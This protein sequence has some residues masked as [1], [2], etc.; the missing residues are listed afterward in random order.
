M[1]TPHDELLDPHFPELNPLC[2]RL[3]ELAT[4]LPDRTDA[5]PAKQ[6]DE[7]A[8]A[9]VLGWVIPEEYGGQ[10]VSTEQLTRGYLRLTEACLTTTFI[11]TQRNG[12]C[13]RLAGSENEQ[14][15]AHLLPALCRGELFATVGISHLTTSRQHLAQP[16]VRAEETATG[17]I[18]DGT[19]PWVT[20]AKAA[21]YIVTG[22]TCDD[23]RQLLVALPTDAKGVEVPA[24]P[25]LLALNA[26]QTGAVRL[27]GVEIPQEFLIA[28]PVENVMKQGTGG[29]AGSLTTSALAT[30]LAAA[31]LHRLEREAEKR[32]DLREVHGALSTEWNSLQRDLFQALG[33]SDPESPQLSAESI[34]RRANSLALR[35]TQAYLAA[36]KGAGFLGSHAASRLVR[37]AMF[38]LVWSCPQPVLA[39]QL[40][41]FACT[42]E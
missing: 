11:L 10:D 24:P 32:P 3:M 33:G 36:T 37:E 5:W 42:L 1:T 17:W 30:G 28:G 7:L 40:Q 8:Q 27:E 20:G 22:G 2:H 41:E 25:E 18:F 21:D 31:A 16:A 15:K 4:D 12:A 26:S 14:L 6:L 9:K 38:F 23:G 19:I 29:G 39:A 13:Q 34:R 35:M